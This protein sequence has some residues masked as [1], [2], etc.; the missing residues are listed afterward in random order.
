MLVL[1]FFVFIC[2]MVVY[3]SDK[4]TLDSPYFCI[5]KDVNDI[6][7]TRLQCLGNVGIESFTHVGASYLGHTQEVLAYKYL[8]LEKNNP[9]RVKCDD[10]RARLEY[11]PLLP[12]DWIATP[13]GTVEQV[14]SKE[15]STYKC[16]YGSLIENIESYVKWR[17]GRIEKNK[18][19][20]FSVV[21]T[22]NFRTALGV[23]GM[24]NQVRRGAQYDTVTSFVTSLIL[25]HYERF[26]QC[27]DLLRKHWPGVIEMPHVPAAL[28]TDNDYDKNKNE[29]EN[30]HKDIDFFF[31]GRLWLFGPER[32]CSV[33]NTIASLSR[34]DILSSSTIKIV[35]TTSIHQSTVPVSSSL[36]NLFYRS[37]F[38]LISKADS[39]S[40]ES[41]YTAIRSECIPI[42]IS[43]WLAPSTNWAIPYE[44]FSIRINEQDFLASPVK[45][46]ETVKAR[47]SSRE[48]EM[49]SQM[50]KWKLLL[51]YSTVP[52]ASTLITKTDIR[53]YKLPTK[54]YTDF[55]TSNGAS[56]SA[57]VVPA[58]EMFL[59]ET[60]YHPKHKET[61]Q[62]STDVTATG[63]SCESPYH[64]PRPD[65]LLVPFQ[66]PGV[67][68]QEG[69]K[70]G[71]HGDERS[72]L[73]QSV[74]RLIGQYKMVYNQ[75]CVR[76]L[77]PLRPGHFKPFDLKLLTDEEKSIVTEFHQ[78][79]YS[80][81]IYPYETSK[82][83][84]T[85]AQG[86]GVLTLEML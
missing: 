73:C 15:N 8:V 40:S 3:G 13:L 75:K 38:C 45:V 65:M 34:S 80:P 82:L 81:I 72:Y 21:G 17:K 79:G 19:T 48:Q 85:T 43:D 26:P 44:E 11:I 78:I 71:K 9:W 76:I 16:S 27:P 56:Q 60:L 84:A 22:I 31:A 29:N 35:N 55:E 32:V 62:S 18:R 53:H 12:L 36:L 86:P 4:V 39:Y 63:L 50:R 70:K 28:F 30:K 37:R 59:F 58:I 67:Q 69:T 46:L 7:G 5:S 54:A 47:C 68:G 77:W 33:R 66:V 74:H 20:L 23:Y 1:T 64:C 24:N 2:V 10:P 25:G 42:I 51:S 6:F 61:P 49:R 14:G 83:A 52:A 57:V 41:L